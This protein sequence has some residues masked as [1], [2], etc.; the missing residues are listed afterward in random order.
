MIICSTLSRLVCTKL[1]LRNKLLV[2][3]FVSNEQESFSSLEYSFVK[4]QENGDGFSSLADEKLQH[5]CKFLINFNDL[6]LT[7]FK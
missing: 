5:D 2:K 1:H 6:S 4:S 3:F 7:C